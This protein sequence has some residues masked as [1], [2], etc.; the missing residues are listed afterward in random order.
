[1]SAAAG[2][3]GSVGCQIAKLRGNRVVAIVGGER[4]VAAVRGFGVDAAIDYKATAD[5]ATAVRAACPGGADLYFDNVGAKTLDVMLPSMR[6]GGRIVVC[7][8]IANYNNAADPYPIRN[9]WQVL[10]HR[11]TMRGFL[12]YEN[13]DML[14]EAEKTLT[15]WITS[16]QLTPLENVTTGVENAP[17]AFIRLMSGQTIGKTVVRLNESVKCLQ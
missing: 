6:D 16:G 7:G 10:V 12:A 4:K 11:L 8:M 2:A 14:A 3:V 9:L 5:L 1:M 13:A 15:G 17:G